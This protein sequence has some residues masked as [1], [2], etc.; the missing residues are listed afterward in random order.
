MFLDVSHKDSGG[1]F[2]TMVII[3]LGGILYLVLVKLLL[4]LFINLRDY[5]V[6]K[7]H[8]FV[9]QHP[10]FIINLIMNGLP[11][12]FKG[13]INYLSLI[14]VIFNRFEYSGQYLL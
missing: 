7:F 13:K 4:H 2:F 12:Y 9:S 5:V 3:E 1:P 6:N 14:D 8:P 11:Q 10:H